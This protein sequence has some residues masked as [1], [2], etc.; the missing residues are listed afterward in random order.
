MRPNRSPVERK[1]VVHLTLDR[2]S[3][4][5]LPSTFGFPPFFFGSIWI[6]FSMESAHT[7]THR[8]TS[9]V[10]MY[11]FP[12][13]C[14]HISFAQLVIFNSSE[15]MSIT[16]HVDGIRMQGL[17][18]CQSNNMKLLTS[19]YEMTSKSQRFTHRRQ[20]DAST[21][22]SSGHVRILTGTRMV[23]AADV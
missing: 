13:H 5:G 3:S 14:F 20:R 19:I 10:S 17:S 15:W 8:G 12:C 18:F 9:L 2:V 4:I 21:G 22:D 1:M 11:T 6:L 16:L 7:N 23:I